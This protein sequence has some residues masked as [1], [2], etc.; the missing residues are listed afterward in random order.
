[1]MSS[2]AVARLS[3]SDEAKAIATLALAFSSDP[4]VRWVYPE[5]HSYLQHFPQLA[6][7][8]GGRAFENTTAFGVHQFAGVALW[9]PPGVHPDFESMGQLLE[10]TVEE[11]AQ[12]S[13]F[14]VLGQMDD[15]HPTDPHWY[16]PL[17]GVDPSRQGQGLGSALLAEVLTEC[18]RQGLPAYLESSNERNIGL[19]ERHGFKVMGK[20]QASDSPG[21]WPMLRQPV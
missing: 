2:M 11:S 1:M 3:E 14:S 20:I 5:P 8:F 18:D 12:E 9:I 10:E 6:R 16:L 13:V 4:V 15:Y 21:I 17:I 7:Y 19:Y